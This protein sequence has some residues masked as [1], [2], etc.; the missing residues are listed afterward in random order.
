MATDGHPHQDIGRKNRKEKI[1]IGK[2]KVRTE[3]IEQEVS[4]ALHKA[5]EDLAVAGQC[6]FPFY[7]GQKDL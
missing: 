4:S 7:R 6:C 2:K 1:R 3:E 5:A